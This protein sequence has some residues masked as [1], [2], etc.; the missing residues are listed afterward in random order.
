[1][2][3]HPRADM[4]SHIIIRPRPWL[5]SDIFLK[6]KNL[7]ESLVTAFSESHPPPL[8]LRH[9]SFHSYLTI[10]LNFTLESRHFNFC[11]VQIIP[12]SHPFRNRWGCQ[13]HHPLEGFGSGAKWNDLKQL[14]GLLQ[15]TLAERFEE[16]FMLLIMRFQSVNKQLLFFCLF[17]TPV[18]SLD[19]ARRKMR[20][21]K[22]QKKW[23]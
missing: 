1:M 12:V 21:I 23:I 18:L 5:I 17:S 10:L 9:D 7:L 4:D 2:E 20:L 8:A 16:L 13:Q 14:M 11:L 3:K 15:W 6:K 19:C 22:A